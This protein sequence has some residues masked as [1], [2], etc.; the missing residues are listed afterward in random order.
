FLWQGRDQTGN[1]ERPEFAAGRPVHLLDLCRRH[2]GAGHHGHAEQRCGNTRLLHMCF[3][4]LTMVVSEPGQP[5]SRLSIGTSSR[6]L[7]CSRRRPDTG[8]CTNRPKIVRL[9]PKNRRFHASVERGIK[10]IPACTERW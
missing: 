7:P 5:E 3:L 10:R 4:S 1:R 6:I 2:G 9:V 8:S